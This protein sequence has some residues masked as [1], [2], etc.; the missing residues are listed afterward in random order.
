MRIAAVRLLTLTC[1]FHF[2]GINN[3]WTFTV[4]AGIPLPAASGTSALA[5]RGMLA[6]CGIGSGALSF[7]RW[8]QAFTRSERAVQRLSRRAVQKILSQPGLA[9]AGLRQTLK[10]AVNRPLK[11]ARWNAAG[12]A[13]KA[14]TAAVGTNMLARPESAA[15]VTGDQIAAHDQRFF[16]RELKSGALHRSGAPPGARAAPPAGRSLS[17]PALPAVQFAPR[18]HLAAWLRSSFAHAARAD[19]SAPTSTSLPPMHRAAPRRSGSFILR[20][21]EAAL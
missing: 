3:G 9:A 14:W 7:R 18:A 5:V 8:S 6:A 12:P 1:F 10:R 11:T 21:R 16:L 4:A 20:A 17:S 13:A 15:R 19:A 2:S